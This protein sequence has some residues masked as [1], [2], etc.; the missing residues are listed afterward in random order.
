MMNFHSVKTA[1]RIMII[2]TLSILDISRTKCFDANNFQLHKQ[3]FILDRLLFELD[4]MLALM[5]DSKTYNSI[6][7]SIAKIRI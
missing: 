5:S 7:Y 4:K 3:E 2:V 1:S 6:P